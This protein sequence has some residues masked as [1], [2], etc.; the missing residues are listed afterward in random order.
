M[1][2]LILL[3]HQKKQ[4][5]SVYTVGLGN[6]VDVNLLRDKIAISTSGKYFHAKDYNYL[7]DIFKEIKDF[8][9]PPKT[10]TITL[11]QD[12]I[13]SNNKEVKVKIVVNSGFKPEIDV[14]SFKNFTSNYGKN[15]QYFGICV[16]SIFH[17]LNKLPLNRSVMNSN[18]D[19][20]YDL[21]DNNIFKNG[22]KLYQNINLG[23]DIG[24]I[25]YED[26]NDSY[27]DYLSKLSN[28]DNIYKRIFK[29]LFRKGANG[30]KFL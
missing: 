7:L 19:F 21:S 23:S 14:Y 6:G 1:E 10:T 29:G 9:E 18:V 16:T 25:D 5:V 24:Y 13:E 15:G 11:R 30:S 28:I 26:H 22:M 4:L 20:D 12:N 27:I 3:M 8:L 2:E 17:Y